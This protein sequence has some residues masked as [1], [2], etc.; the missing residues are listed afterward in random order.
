MALLRT[1]QYDWR[2][3]ASSQMDDRTTEEAFAQIAMTAVA[4]KIPT[5]MEE[6]YRIGFEI[7]KKKDDDENSRMLGVFAMKVG[8]ELLF[9]LAFFMNGEIEGTNLLYRTES[10]SFVPASKEW[11]AYL[12]AKSENIDGRSI[13]KAR[14]SEANPL[15]HMDRI[16]FPPT[17]E[18]GRMKQASTSYTTQSPEYY[19]NELSKEEWAELTGFGPGVRLT[20][21]RPLLAAKIKKACDSWGENIFANCSIQPGA[22]K[23]FLASDLTGVF[24]EVLS[25][26]AASHEVAEAIMFSYPDLSLCNQEC[27]KQASAV[28]DH[29]SLTLYVGDSLEGVKEASADKR[30]DYFRHGFYLDDKR[31]EDTLCV[32]FKNELQSVLESPTVSGEYE[33]LFVGGD[34][35]PAT[36]IKMTTNVPAE[37]SSSHDRPR[38]GYV[39]LDEN[40]LRR[41]NSN[42]IMA[43]YTG[44]LDE[45][46]WRDTP[47]LRK[48]NLLVENDTV[49][50]IGVFSDT[51]EVGGVKS[52]LGAVGGAER[53]WV[54]GD[55]HWVLQNPDLKTT[56]DPN[57]VLGGSV[58]FIPVPIDDYAR[59]QAH[60]STSTVDLQ[61]VGKPN[62]LND[63]MND[64][65]NVCDMKIDKT[66][67]KF[68]IEFGGFGDHSKVKM[69]SLTPVQAA[70]VLAND[71]EV[72]ASSA[73]NLIDVPNG[74]SFR[75]FVGAPVKEASATPRVQI[76]DEPDFSNS[77]SN[78]YGVERQPTRRYALRTMAT[79]QY[80]APARVG[81]AWNPTSP[82]GLPSQAILETAPDKLEELAK[83]YNVPHVFDFAAVGTLAGMSDAL[84][85]IT[86]AQKPLEQ[87][88]D[89]LGRLVFGL[90]WFYEQ[91]KAVYGEDDMGALK[92]DVTNQFERL[93]LLTLD[94]M[95][96]ADNFD[97]GITHN[98][99]VSDD[100]ED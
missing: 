80:P 3:E 66:N 31:P 16:A 40:G 41:A 98:E 28:E 34:L 71:V 22:L 1:N 26:S 93:G 23:D 95:K 24:H 42:D 36:V 37:Y 17:G 60:I 99:E 4:N 77:F 27:V 84:P 29:E 13:S 11:A 12:V 50:G 8:N 88:T 48:A 2:K 64:A 58:K 97:K 5:L 74:S 9:A 89:K 92:N 21:G 81:D 82:N 35:R 83:L 52:Y 30:N 68:D 100:D 57:K 85:L 43:R 33:V 45:S 67:G 72:S 76:I 7:V 96:R 61:D 69:A 14:R 91:F 49:I 87:A 18:Q 53:N 38:T 62:D 44:K 90:I 78:E 54:S 86:A 55:A 32:V 51:K 47:E 94:L 70:V 63:W 79:D 59:E 65:F 56:D 39:I 20:Q 15:M 25:K 6:K 19:E 10:R 46:K 73:M 75:Y